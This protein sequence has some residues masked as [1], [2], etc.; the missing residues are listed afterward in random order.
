MK[1]GKTF[2][3]LH[4]AENKQSHYS[5]I[6]LPV[7]VHTHTHT[8]L[9]LVWTVHSL[10]G[11]ATCHLTKKEN[12]PAEP[13]SEHQQQDTQAHIKVVLVHPHIHSEPVT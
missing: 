4:Y 12:M 2:S 1:F 11:K 9:Y 10:F 6:S 13:V 3:S 8:L 7:V 5:S